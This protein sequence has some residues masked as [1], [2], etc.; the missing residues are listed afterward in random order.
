MEL[1]E[2]DV[3][4]TLESITRFGKATFAA[5]GSAPQTARALAALS[6]PTSALTIIGRDPHGDTLRNILI[7]S[8]VDVSTVIRDESSSTALAVLPIFTDG[9]RGCFVT[10]GAN[11]CASVDSLLS[12]SVVETAFTAGLRVF[13]FGYPHLMPNLQGSNLR[14]LFERVREAAPHVILTMDVNG[15]DVEETPQNPV[16]LPALELVAAIHANLE[17]ACRVSGLASPAE[18][19][20][21]PAKVI[22]PIVKW[23]TQHGVGI[24]CITC[25]KDGVFA[26]TRSSE[27]VPE[28]KGSQGLSPRLEGGA[29]VYKPAFALTEGTQVNASGAGDAFIGG[30]VAELAQTR[31][32]LGIRRVVDAGL[33]GALYRIDSSF[34]KANSGATIGSLLEKADGKSRIPPRSTLSPF[35]AG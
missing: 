25:G 12:R 18:C 16:L 14:S 21:M 1:H 29:F 35:A 32:S 34:S 33:L 19:A 26:A 8:G 7:S 11:L 4:E 17:E 3:P 23:F 13:H 10:L 27:A 15:A 6:V 30:V 5:G 28:E 9:R 20:D 2:C 31:G 24:A 22:E